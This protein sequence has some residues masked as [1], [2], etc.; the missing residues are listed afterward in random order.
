MKIWFIHRA[1]R[2]GERGAVAVFVAVTL[3]ALI[4]FAALAVDVGHLYGVR[5]ELHN[6]ADAGSLAGAQALNGATCDDLDVAA[7]N[8]ALK[9]IAE[10]NTT[11]NEAVQLAVVDPQKDPLLPETYSGPGHWSFAT[12]EFTPSGNDKQLE[13]W[14]NKP[15]SELDGEVDYINAVQVVTERPDTPSF[16][17]G[18]LG[19]FDFSVRAKAVAYIGFAGTLY[20]TE[21]DQPIAICKESITDSKTGGYICN[22]GR[23]LNSSTHLNTS[24]TALWTDFS[25]P[26]TTATNPDM[27]DLT[28]NCIGNNP[29]EVTFG[30]GMGTTN[31]VQ[32]NIF[33]NKNKPGNLTEC[34]IENADSADEDLIPDKFWPLVLPVIDCT[35]EDEGPGC[36]DE[37]PTCKP[38]VGAVMVDVVWINYTNDPLAQM[39]DVPTKMEDWSCD[40]TAT[41]ADR[42]ACWKSFVKHFNLQNVIPPPD[43]V[44]PDSYYEEM[45][46]NNNI[47]FRSNCI[48][49]E[50]KGTTGGENFGICA[51]IPVLVQ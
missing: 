20:P 12:G 44:I 46:R 39:N 37:K 7:A 8:T 32:D 36:E 47:Y 18:I 33:G 4:G 21:L 16:L 22:M 11:G 14:E 23:M 5:N 30:E 27:K 24:E 28:D 49:H 34:W 13:G 43:G 10:G 3:I 50:P 1:G 19:F 9:K 31:G 35:C 29:T 15:F 6:A 40:N 41:R 25:Q 38:L 17:A 48:P 45:Y 26:C 2:Q 42:F 51:R